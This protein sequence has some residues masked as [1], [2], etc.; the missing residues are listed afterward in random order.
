M[1][2]KSQTLIHNL[3]STLEKMHRW[4]MSC[5]T[6]PI[7]LTYKEERKATMCPPPL[8]PK[9]IEFASGLAVIIICPCDDDDDASVFLHVIKMGV[10]EMPS[11]L[12]YRN[13][14]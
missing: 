10:I 7:I 2:Q 4:G 11:F 13:A 9:I 3:M 8:P 5:Q 6:L 1:A 12:R 14:F